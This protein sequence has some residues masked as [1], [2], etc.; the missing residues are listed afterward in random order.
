MGNN[1]M[2]KLPF[3]LRNFGINYLIGIEDFYVFGGE[4]YNDTTHE[5]IP[6]RAVLFFNSRANSWTV[7]P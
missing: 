5:W 7:T 2:A 6:N 1:A 4:R 3:P